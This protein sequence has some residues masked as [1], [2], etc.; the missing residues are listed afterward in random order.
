MLAKLL[1]I[2]W[3]NDLDMLNSPTL[4]ALVGSGQFFDGADDLCIGGVTNSM[5]SGLEAV[6]GRADHEVADFCACQKLETRL[7]SGV[8]IRFFQPRAAAAQGSVEI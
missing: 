2:D 7:P 3:V 6:H 8:S 4:I 1:Q 5:N